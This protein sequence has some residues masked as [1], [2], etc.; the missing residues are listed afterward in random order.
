[1]GLTQQIGNR[2]EDAAVEHLL[3]R[4]FSILHRNWRSGR[5][6]LDIVAEHRGV[7]R[8]VE[9]KTRKASPLTAPEEAMTRKKFDA[10]CR[11]ARFYVELYHIDLEVEFDLVTVEMDP[12][13]SCRA[14]YIPDVMSPRW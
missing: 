6:E 1:M 12:D 8:I 9:V 5:Y 14:E 13:G 11:A 4:G 3:A 10:L 7:L 2:G